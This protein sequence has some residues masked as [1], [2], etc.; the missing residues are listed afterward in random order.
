MKSPLEDLI[1]TKLTSVTFIHDYLQ[2]GFTNRSGLTI[3]NRYHW[4]TKDPSSVIGSNVQEIHEEKNSV[5]FSF[6]NGEKLVVGFK[7]EDFSGPEGMLL[8]IEGSK[9][10]IIWD[11]SYS[12]V[13]PK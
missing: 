8:Y 10:P 4:S 7:K 13:L 9:T 11:E 6:S 2:L 5:A 12:S 3:N 1:D